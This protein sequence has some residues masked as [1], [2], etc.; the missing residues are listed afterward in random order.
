MQKDDFYKQETL[1]D[2]KSS[3]RAS[4]LPKKIGP[5]RI[6]SILSQGGMS[7]LYLGVHPETGQPIAIKVLLPKFLKHKEVNARFLK[8][9]EIIAVANHPNIVKLYG[10]GEWEK[11]LYIAMEFIRGISLSQ[12]IQKKSLSM[13]RALEIV[14]QV[15]YALSHLHAHGV[16][17]RDLKPENILIDESGNVKVI[18]FGIAQ[19]HDEKEKRAILMG[20]PVYMSPEQRE[21]PYEISYSSDLYS[22]GVIAYEL[23]LGQLSHG[24]IHLELLSKPLRKIIGKALER[25]PAK[26]YPD[27]VDFINEVTQYL[28]TIDTKEEER[29]DEM[30]GFIR[31]SEAF[32]I[33]K[34]PD[35]PILECGIARLE[36]ETEHG[37]VLDFFRLDDGR[38]VVLIAEPVS[39]GSSSFLH[40]AF[41]RGM[42]RMGVRSQTKFE[43]IF[44][45]NS[46]N[47]AL[48]DESIKL[49]FSA[50]MLILDG[51]NDLLS[52][53]SCK[54]PEL[55]LISEGSDQIKTLS[56][57]NVLLGAESN[58]T[59]ME[60]IDN[61]RPAD[62]LLLHTSKSD[63]SWLEMRLLSPQHQA[64]KILESDAPSQKMELAVCLNRLF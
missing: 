28:L 1:S 59:F 9:A 38:M 12:F 40:G 44:F 53:V 52:Y 32:L 60:T 18:D 49:S 29:S 24:T 62:T 41:F 25:D 54:G 10:Q 19:L 3:Q 46:L 57:S 45:M 11:G 43:P 26:R 50:A 7:S 55:F 22:L 51:E 36:G 34:K 31:K 15:A 56:N 5:Y 64:E 42:A 4:P 37:T 20:T 13:R 39:S 35:W 21:P 33:Q 23:I 61:W 48:R 63:K 58:P 30:V 17:H 27:V 2:V 6:E 8:E 16:I 47:A 14:L